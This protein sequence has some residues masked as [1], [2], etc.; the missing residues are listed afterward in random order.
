MRIGKCANR[1]MTTGGD[2]SGHGAPPSVQA[3]IHSGEQ[4]RVNR[5]RGE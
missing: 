1:D 5:C 4:R 2:G 3:G